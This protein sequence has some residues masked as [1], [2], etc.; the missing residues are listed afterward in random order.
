[1]RH[2][3]NLLLGCALIVIAGIVGAKGKP[4]NA[5]VVGIWRGEL[6]NLPAATLNITDEAGPSAR[7][8][9]LLFDSAQRR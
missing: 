5:P 6:E 8:H 1:M 4:S 9:A 7:S 2:S 3:T